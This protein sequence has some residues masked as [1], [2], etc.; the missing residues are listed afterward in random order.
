MPADDQ[1]S[2]EHRLRMWPPRSGPRPQAGIVPHDQLD[3]W[4]PPD[5]HQLLVERCL[6]LPSVRTH[7]SRMALAKTLAL[8]LPQHLC[9]G[10]SD[11]FIDDS[12]FC[13]VHTLPGGYLH[14]TLP[15]PLRST[16][17][18]CGWAEPHPS[19]NAGFV[20]GNLVLVYAP[21]NHD[22]LEVAVLLVESSYCFARGIDALSLRRSG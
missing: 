13:H 8:V 7:E 4:P 9:E 6:A 12:E 2:L 14:L 3:Q 18:E 1:L 16:A 19:A 21:R 15:L 22:E 11:A 17:I 10:P 5:I 20:T